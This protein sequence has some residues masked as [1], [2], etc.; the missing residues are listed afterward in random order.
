MGE[1]IGEARSARQQ[2]ES[3]ARERY[4]M[5]RMVWSRMLALPSRLQQRL[6]N[7]TAGDVAAIDREIRDALMETGNG[8]IAAETIPT[9][10]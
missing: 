6:P 1:T 9:T 4:D 2:P 10:L 3:V 8:D 7:L 5:L